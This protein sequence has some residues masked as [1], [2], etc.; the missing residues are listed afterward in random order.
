MD[1]KAG[2]DLD[3]EFPRVEGVPRIDKDRTEKVSTQ[4]PLVFDAGGK[5]AAAANNVS[6]VVRRA[7]RL[8]AKATDRFVTAGEEANGWWQ[9]KEFEVTPD[10]RILQL[11]VM[12]QGAQLLEWRASW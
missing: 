8:V 3:I 12:E 6:L 1:A 7:Q 10:G 5:Q 4:V 11:A 9:F 2:T